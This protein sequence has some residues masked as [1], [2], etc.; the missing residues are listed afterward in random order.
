MCN[1][2]NCNYL[3]KSEFELNSSDVLTSVKYELFSN[4]SNGYVKANIYFGI[5]R[6]EFIP[7][8]IEE[9]YDIIQIWIPKNST[10]H[11][12]PLSG[13]PDY[14]HGMPI[15]S[16]KITQ[17]KI[18]NTT[19]VMETFDFFVSETSYALKNV[20]YFPKNI[21]GICILSNIT[22]NTIKFNENIRA[23][24][25][26][27]HKINIVSDVTI[28]ATNT[29]IDIQNQIFE[30]ISHK[31]EN[32]SIAYVSILGNPSNGFKD[33][34]EIVID[35]TAHVIAGSLEHNDTLV[36][37]N[38]VTSFL[39][40]FVYANVD[41]PDLKIKTVKLL[42]AKIKQ[43]IIDSVHMKIAGGFVSLPIYVKSM[44]Y[45]V[46]VPQNV[47]YAKGPQFHIY[48]PN[49]FFYPFTHNSSSA[50]WKDIFLYELIVLIIFLRKHFCEIQL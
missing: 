29:C 24:C 10:K 1:L 3:N 4:G 21:G 16:S 6:L 40:N 23:S 11:V 41:R 5:R 31:S 15:I 13:N 43:E 36:C 12:Q 42:G 45:D 25:K 50:I 30:I 28:N 9:H 35:K 46:T 26:V 18:V 7:K 22:Y 32:N 27:L 8:Y 34:I 37:N 47:E 49:D 19:E 44:F 14:F 33:W 38:L 2:Q 20:L 17:I 39:Y 48:L